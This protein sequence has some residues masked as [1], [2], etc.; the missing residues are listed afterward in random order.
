MEFAAAFLVSTQLVESAV[1]APGIKSTTKDSESAESLVILNAFSTSASK[2]AS[3]YLNTSNYLMEPAE[4]ALST[5]PTA[6]L[7]RPVSVTVDIFPTLASAPLLAMPLR[8]GRMEPAN[9]RLDTT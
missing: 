7:L 5:L 3:A 2:L 4:S 8:N 9:A 1:N 6:Q